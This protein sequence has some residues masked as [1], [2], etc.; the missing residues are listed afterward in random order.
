V[1]LAELTALALAGELHNPT[2][3]TGT[4][5]LQAA[6]A[7]PGLDGLRPADSPWPARPFS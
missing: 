7:G 4:F 3:V 5:A 1:P 2:L 6:L